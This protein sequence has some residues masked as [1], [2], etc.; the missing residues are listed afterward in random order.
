MDENQINDIEVNGFV[1]LSPSK[2][3]MRAIEIE[4]AKELLKNEGYFVD[5][6]WKTEVITVHY[7]CTE[8]EAQIILKRA[9]SDTNTLEQI[10][11]SIRT[12][13]D[14]MNFKRKY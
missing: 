6:L 14:I 8:D 13:S 10:W 11:W 12:D 7:E 1:N 3:T 9:L 4:K 2:E 5:N